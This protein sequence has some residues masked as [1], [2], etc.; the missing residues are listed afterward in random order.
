MSSHRTSEG[1]SCNTSDY[2]ST[3]F[4]KKVE[5]LATGHAAL[6]GRKD[7]RWLLLDGAISSGAWSS[8][9]LLRAAISSDRL[10]DQ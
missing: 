5:K 9:L 10:A 6:L 1:H 4:L 2:P 3:T 7:D 8:P